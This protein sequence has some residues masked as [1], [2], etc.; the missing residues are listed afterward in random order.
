M[1]QTVVLT[2][3]R[4]DAETLV[5]C[6]RRRDERLCDIRREI[7]EPEA[8]EREEMAYFEREHE[9]VERIMTALRATLN[10]PSDG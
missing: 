4:A 1:E 3:A 2:L 9:V 5:E 10:A 8:F 6:L 7:C